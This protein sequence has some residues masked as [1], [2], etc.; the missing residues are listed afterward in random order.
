M[1]S[2]CAGLYSRG[3][4]AVC[5]INL[6]ILI[7]WRTATIHT[8]GARMGEQPRTHAHLQDWRAGR[9][10]CAIWHKSFS[11]ARHAKVLSIPVVQRGSGC[12]TSE[13]DRTRTDA[14]THAARARV[15][16][17]YYYI[18]ERTRK[19]VRRRRSPIYI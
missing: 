18:R 13:R 16:C 6:L 19:R 12:V 7:R 3:P 1:R 15:H 5:Y 8:A 2:G 4:G 11:R 14:H 10:L 9:V 17:Y